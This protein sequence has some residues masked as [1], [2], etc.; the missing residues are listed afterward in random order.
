MADPN[1]P[2]LTGSR[3][4]E[5][6]IISRL[7]AG[8][9]GFVYEGRQPLIG[10]RVAVK[11]L[12]PQLS[13]DKELVERFVSEARAVNEIGHRGIVD[14]FSFGQLPTGQHYFVM[15]YLDGLPFDRLVKSRAPVPPEE[16]LWW[17]EEICE[18][19]QAAH[20]AGIIHR[21]IKPSNLFLVDTGRGRPYVKLLDFGIAKLGAKLGESTPQ[22]RAS[23]VVGTPDYMSPEQARG[24]AITPATD[25]YA[26]GC[27]MF[28]LLTGRRAFK[29]ENPLETMFMHVENAPPRLRDFVPGLSPELEELLLWTMEKDPLVRPNTAEELRVHIA[30]LRKT[31]PEVVMTP[32]PSPSRRDLPSLS[33]SG[34]QLPVSATPRPPS[35]APRRPSASASGLASAAARPPSGPN[36]RAP[37]GQQ[38]PLAATPPKAEAPSETM[39]LPVRKDVAAIPVELNFTAEHP[40]LQEAVAPSAV[41]A[42]VEVQGVAVEAPVAAPRPASVRAPVGAP[43]AAVLAAVRAR[44]AAEEPV[45][46][47]VEEV[48]AE[49]A[50][51]EATVDPLGS[52]EPTAQHVEEELPPAAAVEAPIEPAPEPVVAARPVAAKA[53]TPPPEE[54]DDEYDEHGRPR[55]SNTVRNGVIV[56]AVVLAIAGVFALRKPK[57]APVDPVVEVKPP[58]EVK[59]PPVLEPMPEKVT[60]ELLK[61]R[62]AKF[63]AQLKEQ[64]AAAGDAN[65]LARQ[66]S[67]KAKADLGKANTEAKRR[68]VWDFLDEM[69]NQ[70]GKR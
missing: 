3:I 15:E 16:A 13:Y 51:V 9:M 42:P 23:M 53:W 48:P 38:P 68:V 66:L 37:S 62:I 26:L 33:P 2:D 24:K 70:L 50:V 21:D 14:I 32:R 25:V 11:V 43:L 40:K 4:G 45:A 59:P 19:L 12:L 65:D 39:A 63:D 58:E 27:V 49:H 22:T 67:I 5:Y 1:V 20:D 29:G 34:R 17:S 54:D 47:L 44:A 7:G 69:Q 52:E 57:E 35:S 31:L 56:A 55:R 8:G 18:A 10:K 41:E 30:E 46:P 60:A 36:A 28:E 61:A 6:D 64:E